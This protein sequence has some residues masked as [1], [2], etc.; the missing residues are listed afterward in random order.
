MFDP[1]MERD[2]YH[3]VVGSTCKEVLG[4]PTK[5]AKLDNQSIVSTKDMIDIQN[6][7]EGILK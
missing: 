4:A 6:L 5:E 1:R 2:Q 7:V 3:E